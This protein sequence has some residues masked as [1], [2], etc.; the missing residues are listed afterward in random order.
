MVAPEMSASFDEKVEALRRLRE[1]RLAK[2]A[3]EKAKQCEVAKESPPLDRQQEDTAQKI[4]KI[5]ESTKSS[6]SLEG[7]ADPAGPGGVAEADA[8]FCAGHCHERGLHGCS[9]DLKAAA[10]MYRLAAEQGHAV[11]QWRLGE[12][13]ESGQGGQLSCDGKEAA[14]WYGLAAEA[15]NAQAQSAL[16]LLLEDGK[17]GVLQDDAKARH[18]HLAAAE[19]GNALSQ[20]C[21]ACLMAEG[22]G[23]SRD[24]GA[25]EQWLRRSAA[26]GFR[27]AS[28]ALEDAGPALPEE[29]PRRME[30]YADS[31]DLLGLAQRIAQQL[32]D[33]DDDEAGVLL[34]ELMAEVPSLLDA[35]AGLGDAG[36]ASDDEDEAELGLQE[37]DSSRSEDDP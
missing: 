2:Q 23:G 29:A 15:G 17:D 35:R 7:K 16:A 24:T 36:D 25:A 30:G 14:H 10:E 26:Q 3:E 6:S 4:G 18:W 27:P 33:L 9:V 22:R 32:G 5:E 8:L 31:G 19:Q 21:L 37:V 28:Q 34:D 12:L 20:Y 1:K 11:A 13:C